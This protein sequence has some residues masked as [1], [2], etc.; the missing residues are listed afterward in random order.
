MFR[1]AHEMFSMLIVD[2]G[3]NLGVKGS[4]AFPLGRDNEDDMSG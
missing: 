4:R 2:A 3:L 1:E